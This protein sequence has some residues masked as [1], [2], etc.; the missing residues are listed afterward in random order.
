MFRIDESDVE[1]YGCIEFNLN[2]TDKNCDIEIY[3]CS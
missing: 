1:I 3:G 2:G